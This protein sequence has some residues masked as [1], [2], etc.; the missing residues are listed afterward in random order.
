MGL[1]DSEWK[2]EFY[3]K[4]RMYQ[5]ARDTDFTEPQS[6]RRASGAG[7]LANKLLG[8]GSFGKPADSQQ[9]CKENNDATISH[10]F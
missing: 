9:E 8:W 5:Y 6:L 7:L 2:L 4:Q 1:P 3:L 10:G